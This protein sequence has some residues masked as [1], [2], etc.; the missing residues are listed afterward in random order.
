V[1]RLLRTIVLLAALAPL[2]GCRSV[3]LKFTA[4]AIAGSGDNYQKDE[5]P[6]LVRDAVPFGLKTMEGVLA[7][8]PEHEGLLTALTSGFTSYGYAFVQQDADLADL[9]GKLELARAGRERA[10]RLY[11]RARGYGLRGLDVRRTD[12]GRRLAVGGADARAALARAEKGDVPLLYW[13]ASAWALAIAADKANMAGIA[14]LPT[15]IAMMERALALDEAWNDG[16]IHEFFVVLDATRT[17]A[18]GGGPERARAHLERALALSMKKKL[19]PRVSYAEG[20]LVQRQDRDA[21]VRTLEE[22]LRADPRE[23]PRYRLVNILA[24]RRARA[25]LAHVDDLFL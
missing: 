6:E 13:T 23:V 12:L 22:V 24:Q 5:D 10:K 15:P 20:V 3:A 17:A 7:E 9:D 18:E 21:F 2:A 11:L 25:L 19:A 16:A 4:D 14:E 1:H 8:K